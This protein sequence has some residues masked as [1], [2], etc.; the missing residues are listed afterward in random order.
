MKTL[1]AQG[2]SEKEILASLKAVYG[3]RVLA[4][5]PKKGFFLSAWIFPFVIL[6]LGFLYLIT[7]LKSKKEKEKAL[8]ADRSGEI[9]ASLKPYLDLFPD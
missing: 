4:A 9:D 8:L 2:K 3:E 7:F 6:S 1:I 5:P